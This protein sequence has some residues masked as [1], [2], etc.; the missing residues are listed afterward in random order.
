MVLEIRHL[1]AVDAIAREG[2]VTAAAERLHLTQSAVSHLLKDLE[3]RLGVALFR[4]ERGMIP[5]EEGQRLLESA[6]RVLEEVERAEYD[7]ERLREGYRGVIRLATEC[8][9]C[10]HW[11]PS[12]LGA[13]IEAHP[14]I[15]L[16]IVP[17]ATLDPLAAIRSEELDLAIVHRPPSDDPGI[18]V[19]HLFDDELVAAVVPAHPLADRRW[20]E[21]EDFVAQTLILHSD[22]EN[23]IVV[24]SFLDPAD[25]RP[26]RILEL[27]LSEAVVETVKTGIGVTV[28][29]RWAIAPHVDAGSLV[30]LRL[31]EG[32]L[33]RTWH[34]AMAI[35]RAD[36]PPMRSLVELLQRDG[37]GAAE[38]CAVQTRSV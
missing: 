3:E 7:L 8:Y 4:R 17:E 1:R 35:R 10:Y 22:P 24:E 2:T 26:A 18:A 19:E 37:L 34:A 21:P 23:S 28:M 32:G 15:D 13:F 29:A 6:R 36:W 9:T 11:L 27:Q 20:L 30:E 38:R 5:T 16:Q 12:I 25:A 31:S 14:E 33:R